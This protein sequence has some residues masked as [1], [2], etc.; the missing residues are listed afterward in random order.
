MWINLI[1]IGEFVVVYRT[2][3]QTLEQKNG[4]IGF[5]QSESLFSFERN[6]LSAD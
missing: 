5:H 2:S 1:D 6:H 4:K 3:A